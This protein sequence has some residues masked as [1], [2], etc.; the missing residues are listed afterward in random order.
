MPVLA[1]RDAAIRED[2]NL[3]RIEGEVVAGDGDAPLAV[4]A[5]GE[6]H[7]GVEQVRGRDGL[8]G[9]G[10]GPAGDEPPALLAVVGETE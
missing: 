1:E 9:R 2:Y 6:N 10:H 8:G 5:G 4:A 3:S 7:E